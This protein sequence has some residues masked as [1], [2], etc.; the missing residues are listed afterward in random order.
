MRLCHSTAKGVVEDPR[1]SSARGRGAGRGTWGAA[2]QP[3]GFTESVEL[4]PSNLRMA[5]VRVALG[6]VVCFLSFGAVF[7][8]EHC[9]RQRLDRDDSTGPTSNNQVVRGCSRFW[10]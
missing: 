1:R 8:A 9:L 7:G 5:L 10:V 2:G 6:G 3:W 4:A